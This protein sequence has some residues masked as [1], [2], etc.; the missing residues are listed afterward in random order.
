VTEGWRVDGGAEEGGDGASAEI[1]GEVVD[2]RF[3]GIA[4]AQGAPF[5]FYLI[6][7]CV[8]HARQGWLMDGGGSVRGRKSGHAKGRR[9]GTH[10]REERKFRGL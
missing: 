4:R 6:T 8:G 5:N 7:W 10:L 1:L 9:H 2:G 3:W